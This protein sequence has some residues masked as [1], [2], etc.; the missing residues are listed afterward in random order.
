MVMCSEGSGTSAATTQYPDQAAEIIVGRFL[1]IR[2]NLRRT[3]E[4]IKQLAEAD[5]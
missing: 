4:G 5:R 2:D 1:T 3:L